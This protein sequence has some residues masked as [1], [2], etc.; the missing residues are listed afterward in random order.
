MFFIMSKVNG[1]N[2]CQTQP[3]YISKKE[4]QVGKEER[5]AITH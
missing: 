2:S 1:N 5:L 4:K 3:N